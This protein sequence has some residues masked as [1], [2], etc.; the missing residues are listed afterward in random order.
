MDYNRLTGEMPRRPWEGNV[1]NSLIPGG[2]LTVRS[3]LFHDFDPELARH[4]HPDGAKDLDPVVHHVR[5]V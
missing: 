3:S 1:R 4:D 2:N 5:R